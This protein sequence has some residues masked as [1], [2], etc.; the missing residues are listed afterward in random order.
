MLS[1]ID[2]VLNRNY[3]SRLLASDEKIDATPFSAQLASLQTRP[4]NLN[5]A[6]LIS[7]LLKTA[8]P[9]EA[10]RY[11]LVDAMTNLPSQAAI[12]AGPGVPV[13][14]SGPPPSGS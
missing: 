8:M 3:E 14:A 1:A 13:A 9:F 4:I 11:D 12:A 2:L 6:V 10:P 5:R 7:P